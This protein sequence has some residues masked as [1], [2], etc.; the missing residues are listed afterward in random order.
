M[1][2][3]TP[4]APAAQVGSTHTPTAPAAQVGSTQTPAAPV[5]RI[6]TT[7]TPA[8]PASRIGMTQTA[9]PPASTLAQTQTE[10]SPLTAD[11]DSQ[12]LTTQTKTKQIQTDK[13]GPSEAELKSRALLQ[14]L[15]DEKMRLVRDKEDWEREKA[16]QELSFQIA[17]HPLPP[18]DHRDDPL[19]SDERAEP[20]AA[21][22]PMT[23]VTRHLPLTT[24]MEQSE[25]EEEE[26]NKVEKLM[27]E[28]TADEREGRVNVEKRKQMWDA[29][30]KQ[31]RARRDKRGK[32]EGEGP[33][34]KRRDKLRTILRD[35][36]GRRERPTVHDLMEVEQQ[37]REVTDT[38]QIEKEQ[39]AMD[40]EEV[41]TRHE[42]SDAIMT[43]PAPETDVMDAQPST[44]RTY[45]TMEVQQPV[46]AV[47]TYV[48][49]TAVV[50]QPSTPIL[51]EVIGPEG[52]EQRGPT[53][54]EPPD[55][56]SHRLPDPNAEVAVVEGDNVVRVRFDN[57][58]ERIV[59][60][61]GRNLERPQRS[62]T[63]ASYRG[64]T[65]SAVAQTARRITQERLDELNGVTRG[66]QAR[67]T[68]ARS[69]VPV[70]TTARQQKRKRDSLNVSVRSDTSSRGTS[71]QRR[72]PA[73]KETKKPQP[74][75]K[76]TPRQRSKRKADPDKTLEQLH[77]PVNKKLGYRVKAKTKLKRAP[78]S[79]GNRRGKSKRKASDKGGEE[80]EEQFRQQYEP[81]KKGRRRGDDDDDDASAAPG[82]IS[83]VLT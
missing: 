62:Q 7:Q 80:E 53:V 78:A 43:D 50:P 18:E 2:T 58:T 6:G 42:V 70:R 67:R 65:P 22:T 32:A 44:A 31:S 48:P 68:R 71:R 16:E 8:A 10:P 52:S 79:E 38:P 56:P 74:P 64:K 54:E 37:I 17:R 13:E 45:E 66:R 30:V 49:M 77:E 29:I 51:R 24:I 47:H 23:G 41:V 75:P 72:S 82:G 5:S 14:E 9:Q 55:S 26:A 63:V 59:P 76:P 4:A 11:Q 20:T 73:R 57:G 61:R 12:T 60:R 1:E 28:V 36:S 33:D 25:E 27:A 40:D 15:M 46:R 19:L 81:Q 34:Q 69:D 83:N 39:T 3:Q 35:S 21:V